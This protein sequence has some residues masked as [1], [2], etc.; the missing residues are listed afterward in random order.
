V[1]FTSSDAPSQEMVSQ[2]VAFPTTQDEVI[3]AV[4]RTYGMIVL[5]EKKCIEVHLE[6]AQLA[7]EALPGV[8]PGLNIEQ[9]QTFLDMHKTLLNE[10]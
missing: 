6:Q 3:A 10:Q 2:L 7:E 9:Y 5:M 8:Q 4:D 1:E